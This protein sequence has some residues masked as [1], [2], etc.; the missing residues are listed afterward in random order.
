VVAAGWDSV[1]LDLG[2]EEG[3]ARLPMPEP[4]LGTRALTGAALER[5][6]DVGELLRL[7]EVRPELPGQ[8]A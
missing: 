1:V 5:A 3:L 4:G 7:L 8:L 2:E 6:R